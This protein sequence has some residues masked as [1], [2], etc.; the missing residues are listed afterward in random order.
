ME[1][2]E[3]R[4]GRSLWLLTIGNNSW[5]NGAGTR[6]S[7]GAALRIEDRRFGRLKRV[8]RIPFVNGEETG[9]GKVL[10]GLL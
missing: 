2:V 6:S 9:G 7:G 1:G 3:V 10:T 5:T 4:G 8:F